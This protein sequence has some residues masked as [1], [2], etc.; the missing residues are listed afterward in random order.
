MYCD[1]LREVLSKIELNTLISTIVGG[2]L[3]LMPTLAIW[4]LNNFVHNRHLRSATRAAF[5]AE[6]IGILDEATRRGEMAMLQKAVKQ[7]ELGEE[8]SLSSFVDESLPLDPVF[9]SHVDCIGMLKPKLAGAIVSFYRQLK[10]L[11]FDLRELTSKKQS[12]TK[13]QQLSRL[14]SVLTRW[15][16][17]NGNAQQL[18]RWLN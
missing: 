3:A 10:S 8:I 12:L 14:R 2:L 5:R 18:L 13:E 7:L 16:E 17:L 9:K 1:V 4:L 6:I 15:E 11:R